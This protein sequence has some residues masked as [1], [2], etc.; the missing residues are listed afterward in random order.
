ML[1]VLETSGIQKHTQEINTLKAIYSEPI[2]NINKCREAQSSSSKIRN[3]FTLYI[4][5][6]FYSIQ[7]KILART[8]RHNE[9]KVTQI[10]KERFKISLF[11]IPNISSKKLLEVIK[12][13]GWS[14]D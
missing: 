10:E 7:L 4:S 6:Q 12:Q 14:Q 3:K 11:T 1:K 9:I 8:I 5:I 13:I 2:A